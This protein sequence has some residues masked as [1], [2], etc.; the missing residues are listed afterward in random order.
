MGEPLL[1]DTLEQKIEYARKKGLNVLIL[2]NG[3]LLSV[4]MFKRMDKIG[5][6]SVRISFYGDDPISYIKMHGITLDFW[7]WIDLQK[8]VG[9]GLV[10]DVIVLSQASQRS[11]VNKRSY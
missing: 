5:V 4:E 1:D 7:H 3:S 11:A 10:K 2:S 9:S 8:G 6:S